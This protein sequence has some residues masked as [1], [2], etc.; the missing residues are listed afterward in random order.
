[1]PIRPEN[2]T[3]YPKD[4]PAISASI[5]ARAG[6][7]CEQCGVANG[8]LGGRTPDG[9]WHPA[10]PVGEKLLHMEWPKPGTRWAC[11]KDS[12]RPIELRIIRIVLTVAHLDHQPENC[13]PSNLRAWCQ[14]CHLH[15]DRHHHAKTSYATRKAAA[16]TPDMWG[17][18]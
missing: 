3:R 10:W 5:R 13:D 18:S 4:W 7:R 8:A 6:N 9:A 17:E 2:R 16:R 1:M 15:Y 12:K 14:R 11:G